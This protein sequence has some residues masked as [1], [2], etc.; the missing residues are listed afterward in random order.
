VAATAGWADDCSATA[1]AAGMKAI[2]NAMIRRR[3]FS[4][5]LIEGY[6]E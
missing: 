2:A 6:N 3:M 1:V 5:S 4:F